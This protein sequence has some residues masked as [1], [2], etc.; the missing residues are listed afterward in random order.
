MSSSAVPAFRHSSRHFFYVPT[1]VPALLLAAS[2]TGISAW[3]SIIAGAER[4]GATSERVAWAAVGLVLL[5]GAHLIPAL[6]RGSALNVR[7]AAM[8]LWLVCMASTGYGH[9]TFFLAAQRHAGE[10]RAARVQQNLPAVASP[11][12]RAPDI[13]ARDQVRVTRALLEARSAHCNARCESLAVRRE[14]LAAQLAAL[15]TE[16]DE[17]R[18]REQTADREAA[19]RDAMQARADFAR[20][21]PVTSRIADVLGARRA[22]VDLVVALA[23]GLLLEAVACLGWMVALGDP[24]TGSSEEAAMASPGNAAFVAGNARSGAG[25][26]APAPVSQPGTGYNVAVTPRDATGTTGNV[27]STPCTAGVAGAELVQLTGAIADGRVR[28]TVKD[29]RRFMHCSQAKAMR[30]RRQFLEVAHWSPD[31]EQRA[32]ARTGAAAVRPRL[33]HCLAADQ[34]QAA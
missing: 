21:D 9:A 24:G 10:V 25:M 8:L 7:S 30:L 19:A 32:A 15:G 1:R 16:A 28:P 12:G 14:T 22:T 13:I 20:N 29:I 6:V 34:S 23:T 3:I 27:H 2:A 17:A 26:E 11:S 5:L 4:G 18:R 31:S 33:V